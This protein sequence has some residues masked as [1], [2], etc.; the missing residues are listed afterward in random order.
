M[1]D[2]QQPGDRQRPLRKCYR[3]FTEGEIPEIDRLSI[4]MEV[5][6]EMLPEERRAALGYVAD[7]YHFRIQIK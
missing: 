5:L 2:D 3:L 1:T 6:R 7:F 4:I